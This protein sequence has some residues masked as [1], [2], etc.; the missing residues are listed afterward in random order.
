MKLSEK[1]RK[2]AEHEQDNDD[3]WTETLFEISEEIEELEKELEFLRLYYKSTLH[4][5]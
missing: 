2:Y 4:L 1:V 3:Y 5:R